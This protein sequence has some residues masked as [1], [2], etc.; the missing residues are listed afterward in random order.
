M[1]VCYRGDEAR[2]REEEQDAQEEEKERAEEEEKERRNP[3]VETKKV[4]PE[5]QSASGPPPVPTGSMRP[6]ATMA[7]SQGGCSEVLR[8]HSDVVFGLQPGTAAG[9]QQYHWQNLSV[10]KSLRK[11]KDGPFWSNFNRIPPSAF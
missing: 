2:I 10:L 6:V 8:E 9:H 7:I 3:G 5:P 4:P 11:A 1:S